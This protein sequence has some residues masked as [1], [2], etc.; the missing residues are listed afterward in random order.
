MSRDES[1]F[2][3]ED[4]REK[5]RISLRTLLGEVAFATAQLKTMLIVSALSSPA[6]SPGGDET[7]T[8]YSV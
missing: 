3:M 4:G 1:Q 8:A 2:A 5:C 7:A 6:R